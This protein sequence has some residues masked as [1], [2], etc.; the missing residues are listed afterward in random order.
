MKTENTLTENSGGNHEL[1]EIVSSMIS[2]HIEEINGKVVKTS[3]REQPT[4]TFV[5]KEEG[6]KIGSENRPGTPVSYLN[7]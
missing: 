3:A 7:N 5:G 4:E 6:Q 1:K 2:H